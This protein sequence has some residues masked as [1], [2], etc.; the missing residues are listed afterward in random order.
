MNVRGSDPVTHL[1]AQKH[2]NGE[3]ARPHI[4]FGHRSASQRTRPSSSG[5]IN[6]PVVLLLTPFS[7]TGRVN[8]PSEYDE[9]A[10]LHRKHTLETS[11]ATVALL[12][13]HTHTHKHPIS[14]CLF[15]PLSFPLLFSHA[16]LTGLLP[17]YSPLAC[18]KPLLVVQP[19]AELWFLCTLLLPFLFHHQKNPQKSCFSV[20]FF[21]IYLKKRKFYIIFLSKTKKITCNSCNITS[22]SNC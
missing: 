1:A 5:H 11:S 16:D 7:V 3:C 12:L 2:K 4:W 14:L 6:P 15:T 20:F 13:T 22:V 17:S 19:P 9:W 18:K 8:P 21:V 10:I